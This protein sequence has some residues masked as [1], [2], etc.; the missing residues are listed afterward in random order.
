MNRGGVAI[1]LK[2]HISNVSSSNLGSFNADFANHFLYPLRNESK[3]G[4]SIDHNH[5][6]RFPVSTSTLIHGH[7]HVLQ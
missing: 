7:L 1:I 3:S 5:D 6:Q 2:T 4:T